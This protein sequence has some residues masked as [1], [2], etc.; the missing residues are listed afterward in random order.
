MHQDLGLVPTLG[1]IDNLALGRGYL[2]GPTGTISW[3]RERAAGRELLAALGYDFDVDFLAPVSR[4]TASERTGIAIAR[5]LEGWEGQVKLLVLDEPTASLPAAEVARLFEV[6]RMVH[7]RGVSI[8]YV[9]HHFNE[10]FEISDHVTVL[11]DGRHI[12]TRPTAELDEPALIEL[13]IGRALQDFEPA[14]GE[15]P[16][17]AADAVLQLHSVG[18]SVIEG[19]DRRPRRGGR[20]RRGRDG[21]GTRGG[22]RPR[23]R[24]ARSHRRHHGRG[25][26][27]AGDV[28]RR[29]RLGKVGRR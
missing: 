4:L 16:D 22:G 25:E 23:V 26:G 27:R 2:R 12:A 1:A 24:R 8:I 21:V 18:G 9:S 7:Q 5:A 13:T 15:A 3:R 19:L 29:R 11:R 6:V 28:E 10:V 14:H 17:A 20:R